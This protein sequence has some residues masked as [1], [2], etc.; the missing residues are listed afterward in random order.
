MCNLNLD[1]V[2]T[3]LI[4]YLRQLTYTTLTRYA[5]SA[6]SYCFTSGLPAASAAGVSAGL[7]WT[8]RLAVSLEVPDRHQAQ[9]SGGGQVQVLDTAKEKEHKSMQR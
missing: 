5:M 2:L 8:P 6:V 4:A 9:C 1:C 3:T 7:C